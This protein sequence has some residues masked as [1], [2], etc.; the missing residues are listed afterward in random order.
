MMK[1][2]VPTAGFRSMPRKAVKTTNIII[3]PPEPTKPV[4]KPMVRPKN[5]EIRVPFPSSFAPFPTVSFAIY[6]SYEVLQD[7]INAP[8]RIAPAEEAEL[9]L[10]LAGKACGWKN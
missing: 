8:D 9:I 6:G 1:V 7:W 3:P 10:G 4:P 2:L 5:S